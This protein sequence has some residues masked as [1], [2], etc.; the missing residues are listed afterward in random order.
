MLQSVFNGDQAAYD[1][2]KP[3][4]IMAAKAAY[5][6]SVAIYTAGEAD[7]TYTA[8]AQHLADACLSLFYQL[9]AMGAKWL[10]PFGKRVVAERRRIGALDDLLLQGGRDFEKLIDA[11]P[12][13]VAGA[14]AFA[15]ADPFVERVDS[16]NAEAAHLLARGSVG[17]FA[18]GAD[19]ADKALC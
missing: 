8:S 10:K 16:F 19:A 2:V 15:A 14:E 4:H 9:A 13:H 18:V 17:S 12:S 11:A 5:P 3:A 1:A 6:D 7:P